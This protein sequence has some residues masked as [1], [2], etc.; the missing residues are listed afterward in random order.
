MIIAIFLGGNM[1]NE[2][3]NQERFG[4]IDLARGYCI[5]CV[6]FGH[7]PEEG[8][9]FVDWVYSFHLPM[10]FILSGYL[11]HPNKY[12]FKSFTLKKIRKLLVPYFFMGF[13]IVMLNWC[14]YDL[15]DVEAFKNYIVELLIQNRFHTIWYL[16]CIFVTEMLFYIMVKYMA[17]RIWKVGVMV[18]ALGALGIV[19]Y[20]TGGQPLPWNIDV[21]TTA[22][23]Y[24]FIGYVG[25]SIMLKTKVPYLIGAIVVNIACVAGNMYFTGKELEMFNCEYAI[26]P[27][28]VIGS[29]AGCYAI[30]IISHYWNV[31]PV[32]FI[33]KHSMVYFGLHQALAIPFAEIIYNSVGLFTDRSSAQIKLAYVL[34]TMMFSTAVLTLVYHMFAHNVLKIGI[35]E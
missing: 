27:L 31:E 24:F 10:F 1:E 23:F 6:I 2:K 26:L 35:G 18:I 9:I 15:G 17:D 5:L 32:G 20:S 12:S 33:G 14:F 3:K 34:A 22:M 28:T 4:W 21:C 16:T 8:G 13:I 7:M 29:L 11:F 19:Y 25:Q 30:Y